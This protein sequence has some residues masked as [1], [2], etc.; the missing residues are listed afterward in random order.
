MIKYPRTAHVQGSEFQA[1]DEDLAAVPFSMIAGRF[2][3][4]EEKVDGA[5]LGISFSAQGTMFL[6]C[7]GHFLSGG[8][9]EKQFAL[10]KAWAAVQEKV[11]WALLG[12]QY[13]LYGEWLFA[14]HSVFYDA[15]PHYFLAFDLQDRKTGLFLSGARRREI[16]MNS[17]IQCLPVLFAGKLNEPKQLVSLLGPSQFITGS[18]FEKMKAAY[19]KAGSK[20]EAKPQDSTMEGVYIKLEADGVVLDRYKFVR[21]NFRG[22]VEQSG[23]DW[24]SRPIIQNALQEGVDIYAC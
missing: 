13:T 21:S 2:V 20:E 16:L 14:K 22:L 12:S 18:N 4:I 1:G 10:C 8:G 9:R 24:H 7:R 3:T 11:L 19:Q 23:G 15:L 6:Q 5:N 17:S